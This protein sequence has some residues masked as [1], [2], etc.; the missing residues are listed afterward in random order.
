MKRNFEAP[1]F[2]MRILWMNLPVLAYGLRRFSRFAF[3]GSLNL[4]VGRILI[5]IKPFVIV[6][7]R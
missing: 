4:L 3:E 6:K 2:A 1:G 7:K 5:E